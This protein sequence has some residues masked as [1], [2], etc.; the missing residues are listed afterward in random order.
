M[1]MGVLAASV[2]MPCV[3]AWRSEKGILSSGTGVIDHFE[4]TCKC[5]ELN[6]GSLGKAASV[7]TPEPSLQSLCE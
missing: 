2:S 5:W 6:P 1:Y 7:L 3:C 4:P